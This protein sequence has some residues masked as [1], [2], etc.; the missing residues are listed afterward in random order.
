MLFLSKKK[1][2]HLLREIE[3]IAY[4]RDSF[5]KFDNPL[6]PLYKMYKD[7]KEERAMDEGNNNAVEAILRILARYGVERK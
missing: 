1:I 3:E 6:N 2:H 7:R 4:P 5:D